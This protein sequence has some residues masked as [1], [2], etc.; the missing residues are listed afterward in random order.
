MDASFVNV[1]ESFLGLL[2]VFFGYI[3][4]YLGKKKKINGIVGFR[5]SPTLR[6]P[7]VWMKTNT[8]TGLLMILHGLSL[9]IL[10]LILPLVY[11]PFF[12]LI[13][14]LLPLTI[15]FAYGIWYAYHLEN[16]LRNI[17]KCTT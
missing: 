2:F 11:Q 14:L 16:Q 7:E 1:F 15:Y 13:T 17:P 6:N 9:I 12:L 3:T 5:I 10:G 4:Y 8:R